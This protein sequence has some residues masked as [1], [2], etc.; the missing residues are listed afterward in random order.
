M[1]EQYQITV[2]IAEDSKI[3]QEKL[4]SLFSFE[5]QIKILG[6][7]SSGKEVLPCIKN[8]VP[9]I[10][11]LDIDMESPRAGLDVVKNIKKLYPQIKIIMLT[12]IDSED[13]IIEAFEVG[14]DDYLLKDSGSMEIIYSIKAAY[15][16]NIT[17][18][19]K[20]AK[21]IKKE[22]MHIRRSKDQLRLIL[23]IVS[24]IT[25]SE[26]QI[27]AQLLMGKK[28]KEVANSLYVELSTV[29]THINRLLKKFKMKSSVEMVNFI[30][31]TCLLDFLKDRITS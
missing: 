14:A 8:G 3:L 25:P 22:I 29:K 24:Q 23:N 7:V 2:I 20:I 31:E 5:E 12:A 19:P 21:K 28:Q 18:K 15:T 27:L 26:I 6:I 11:L 30:K 1:E 13:I 9:D 10:A 4:K 17:I 16:G